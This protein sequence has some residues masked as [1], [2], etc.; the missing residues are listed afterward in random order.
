MT[1]LDD[2]G[3]VDDYDACDDG[4]KSDFTIYD[5]QCLIDF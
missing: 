3:G 1:R 5:T 2:Y 4:R